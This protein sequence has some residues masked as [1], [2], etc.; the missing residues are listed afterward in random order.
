MIVRKSEIIN[1]LSE[2]RLTSGDFITEQ[3]ETCA[4]GAILYQLV[5][6]GTSVEQLNLLGDFNAPRALAKKAIPFIK[7][8]DYLSALS[9]HFEN[10]MWHYNDV[11]N[12]EVRDEL[13]AFVEKQFPY[14][15]SINMGLFQDETGGRV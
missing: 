10:V 12:E 6:P 5:P 3:G 15:I 11:Y 4:V 1:I 9:I 13:L 8:G 2:T 7:S 14:E